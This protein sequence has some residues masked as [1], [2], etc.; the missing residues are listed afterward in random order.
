MSDEISVDELSAEYMRIRRE[1]EELKSKF[2][3]ED[4]KLDSRMGD[5]EQALLE[6]MMSADLSS[7]STSNAIV[8]RRVER[9]YSTSNWDEIYR[10]IE[11]HKAFGLLHKRIHD[12]NMR[13]FLEENPDEYPENLNVSSRHAVTVKRK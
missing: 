2:T 4:G 10:L 12:T 7:M 3:E 11:K 13:E 5:I 9:R 8:I 6:K 1:R